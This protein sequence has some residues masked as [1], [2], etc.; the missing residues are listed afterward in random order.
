MTDV[1]ARFWA[2]VAKSETCWEWQAAR[3]LGYGRFKVRGKLVLAHRFVIILLGGEIPD[4]YEVDHKCFN[5][6][7]VRP[8][9]LRFLPKEQNAALHAPGCSCPHH[10]PARYLRSTCA[11]GHDL[12]APGM[13]TTAPRKDRGTVTRKCRDCE[14][15][16]NRDRMR[17]AR[18]AIRSARIGA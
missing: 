16:R 15:R 3:T 6:A 4:G 9:H 2:K 11:A 10:D 5:R 7:C 14:R 18:D 17:V 8:D 12:S 13:L 1:S